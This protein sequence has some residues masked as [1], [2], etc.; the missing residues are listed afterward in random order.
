M[1]QLA[2]ERFEI[3]KESFVLGAISITDLT[4]AQRE[5]DQTAREYIFTLS[6]YWQNYY[7]LKTMTLYDFDNN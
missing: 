7:E 1:K 2:Q 3:I 4:L 6:Q 5:K